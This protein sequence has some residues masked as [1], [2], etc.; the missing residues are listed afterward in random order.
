MTVLHK[1]LG[2]SAVALLTIATLWV[3]RKPTGR[4]TGDHPQNCNTLLKITNI[5][6]RDII[7]NATTIKVLVPTGDQEPGSVM[8]LL[9][10]RSISYGGSLT[11]YAV[12][13]K[14]SPIWLSTDEYTNGW[15]RLE[16]RD[17]TGRSTSYLVRFL[18]DIYHISV[19]GLFDPVAPGWKGE[20]PKFARISAFLADAKTWT[21]SIKSTSNP[22]STVR[23]Y[24]GTGTDI[25]VRWDGKDSA[26]RSVPDDSYNVLLQAG[27]GYRHTATVNKIS[28]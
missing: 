22:S 12:L 10:G 11:Q 16:L 18:N 6:D 23:I 1:K 15:H 19:D 21:V 2:V 7:S 14:P 17:R 27:K 4:F 28:A 25:Y 9:D 26:G 3:L 13:D 5:K 24:H 20:P 8:L